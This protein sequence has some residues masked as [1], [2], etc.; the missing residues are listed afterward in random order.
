M[1]GSAGRQRREQVVHHTSVSRV[2]E[3]IGL[4]G[5]NLLAEAMHL[6]LDIQIQP[7]RNP[8]EA[9][10]LFDLVIPPHLV[11]RGAGKEMA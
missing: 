11:R 8:R 9:N 10:Y 1:Q 7:R 2:G 3:G 6:R 4:W 5:V